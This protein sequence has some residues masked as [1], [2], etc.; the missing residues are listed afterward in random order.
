MPRRSPSSR[1]AKTRATGSPPYAAPA[2]RSRA[3]REVRVAA[4]I[5]TRRAAPSEADRALHLSVN[6][7]VRHKFRDFVTPAERPAATI[8]K[9]IIRAPARSLLCVPTSS[10]TQTHDEEDFMPAK[11]GRTKRSEKGLLTPDNCVV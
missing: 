10:Q 11:D 7:G 2:S 3:K 6:T 9:P 4:S 8:G 5:V 1:S